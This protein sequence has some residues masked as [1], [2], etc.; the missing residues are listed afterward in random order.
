[1]TKAHPN[2]RYNSILPYT[3]NNLFI[4]GNENGLYRKSLSYKDSRE[5]RN[6][7]WLHE[8]QLIRGYENVP[9]TVI[10]GKSFDAFMAMHLSAVPILDKHGVD[11]VKLNEKT[12]EP[13]ELEF[14]LGTINSKRIF[15][16]PNGGPKV[17][18]P[19]ETALSSLKKAGG[20]SGVKSATWAVTN[21]NLASKRLKTGI[22]LR[23]EITNDIIETRYFD[24]DVIMDVIGPL[25]SN[26]KGTID[27]TMSIAQFLKLYPDDSNMIEIDG[28][29]QIGFN[30]YV[31]SIK[32]KCIY[33]HYGKYLTQWA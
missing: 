14:K 7:F 10:E 16:G 2:D 25:P 1:M 31:S 26:I 6:L 19:G 4:A 5:P 29:K 21:K 15:F 20:L 23:D 13:E 12:G 3:D 18:T 9:S 33:S 28:V 22:L 24:G 17:T 11:G 32:D 30:S 8:N 27:R